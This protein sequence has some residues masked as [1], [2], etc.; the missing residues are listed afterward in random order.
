MNTISTR[1]LSKEVGTQL[2]IRRSFSRGEIM[3]AIKGLGLHPEGRWE[4]R[5]RDN[6]SMPPKGWPCGL[7]MVLERRVLTH[8]LSISN[9]L[10]Y[11]NVFRHEDGV[12]I[13][14]GLDVDIDRALIKRIYDAL[15]F[16]A[17]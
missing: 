5:M 7:G 4:S 8:W 14:V 11:A 15:C 1:E 13:V 9:D 2:T 17:A 6:E 12:C 10:A 3:G 16:V